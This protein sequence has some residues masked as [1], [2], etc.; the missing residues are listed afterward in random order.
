MLGASSYNFEDKGKYYLHLSSTERQW[1]IFPFILV[2]HEQIL[3]TFL[4]FFFFP[5][6]LRP[7]PHPVY[8]K[9]T[10]LVISSVWLHILMFWYEEINI[11]YQINLF[12]TYSIFI[13]FLNEFA[14]TKHQSFQG[15]WVWILLLEYNFKMQMTK[16]PKRFRI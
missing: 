10:I 13:S 5:R 14:L 3:G 8:V 16:E 12:L 2:I 4:F 7:S 9:V 11:I 15:Y 6:S 1:L